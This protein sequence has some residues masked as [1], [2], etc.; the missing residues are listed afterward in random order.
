MPESVGIVLA[1][2]L[3]FV[4][5]TCVWILS[6]DPHPQI[7][8]EYG[9][10]EGRREGRSEGR[11]EGRKWEEEEREGGEKKIKREEEGGKQKLGQ[12]KFSFLAC[13]P[14][15]LFSCLLSFMILNI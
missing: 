13:F 1:T 4:P 14:S 7:L 10:K 8:P 6:F 2:G 3:E 11:K 12:N 9:R 5:I 15:L